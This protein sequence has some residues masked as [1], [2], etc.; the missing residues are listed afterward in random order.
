MMPALPRLSCS[1]ERRIDFSAEDASKVTRLC[2]VM[3]GAQGSFT[4][5]DHAQD[6][7]GGLITSTY[8]DG[9]WQSFGHCS[10]L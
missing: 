4:G 3:L 8:A 10:L 2:G 1:P 5:G 7:E 6:I 9:V